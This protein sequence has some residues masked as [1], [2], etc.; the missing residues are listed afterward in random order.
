[1]LR[2]LEFKSRICSNDL[3]L[4]HECDEEN[5]TTASSTVEADDILMTGDLNPNERNVTAPR[6]SIYLI[7]LLHLIYFQSGVDSFLN[8]KFYSIIHFVVS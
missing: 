8:Q 1:M 5:E 2:T 6:R 4:E 3:E 7:S